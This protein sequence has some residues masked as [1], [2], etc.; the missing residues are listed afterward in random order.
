VADS[1]DVYAVEH[2]RTEEQPPALVDEQLTD[3]E[4]AAVGR[5]APAGTPR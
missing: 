1:P 5:A 4:R 3:G 2:R